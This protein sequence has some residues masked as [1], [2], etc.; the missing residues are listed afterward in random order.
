MKGI[1]NAEGWE[2]ITPDDQNDWLNQRD[3]SFDAFIKIGDKKDNVEPVIF[4]T[5][6]RGVKTNRDAWCLQLLRERPLEKNIDRT[7]RFLQSTEID[8]IFRTAGDH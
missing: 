3:A 4:E 7:D 2:R 5:H 1:S 8:A 6:S